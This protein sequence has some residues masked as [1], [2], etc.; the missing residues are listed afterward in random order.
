MKD[1]VVSI[2]IPSEARNLALE[3]RRDSSSSANKNGE[4]PRND[5]LGELFGSRASGSLAGAKC[6]GF[7]SL[8]NLD[9]KGDDC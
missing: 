1:A 5:R 2:V 9:V 4:T 8:Q 3:T 7:L 6:R